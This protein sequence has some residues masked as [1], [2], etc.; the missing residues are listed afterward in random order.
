MH[1]INTYYKTYGVCI[2]LTTSSHPY[3]LNFVTYAFH[4]VSCLL[5]TLKLIY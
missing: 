3:K 5:N 4:A 2:V 1:D